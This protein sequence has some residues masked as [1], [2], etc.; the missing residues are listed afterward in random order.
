M[1]RKLPVWLLGLANF[2]IGATG[3]VALLIAPQVLSSRHVPEAQIA[4]ITSLGLM[5]AFA[6][7]IL[8]PILDIH[9]SRRTYALVL[10]SA[11]AILTFI[12]VLSFSAVNVLGLWLFL[13]LLAALLNSA[14]IGGWFGSVLSNE[15]DAPLGA[16]MSVANAGGFGVTSIAGIVLIHHTSQW[17]AATILGGFDFLPLFIILWVQPPSDERGRI[18]ETFGKFAKELAQIARRPDVQRLFLLFALPCA[19]FA[20]TNTLGGLGA[21]YHASEA[22][23][24]AIAGF[25]VI[26]RAFLEVSSFL[27]STSGLRS[28]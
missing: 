2:P 19:C 13:A 23:I 21:D 22:L 11:A 9:F 16:W 15:Y 3:A 17:L 26:S 1:R 14:A 5:S 24:A 6:S 10:S 27:F 7:F 18:R 12:S 20:L 8:A 4:N 28:S 25:G